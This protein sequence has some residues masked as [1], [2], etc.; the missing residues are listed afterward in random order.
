MSF[1]LNALVGKLTLLDVLD[2]LA[3][4]PK[5]SKVGVNMENGTLTAN[6]TPLMSPPWPLIGR[7]NMPMVGYVKPAGV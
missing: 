6:S 7:V 3:I 4:T 1:V 5:P 2:T